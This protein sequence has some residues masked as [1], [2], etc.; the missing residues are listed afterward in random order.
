MA[1]SRTL[2]TMQHQLLCYDTQWSHFRNSLIPHRSSDGEKLQENKTL[3]IGKE[4][5]GLSWQIITLHHLVARPHN[6]RNSFFIVI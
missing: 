1:V 4:V 5:F 6:M 3:L 2:F